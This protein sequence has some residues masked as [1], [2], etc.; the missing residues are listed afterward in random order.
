[1]ETKIDEA[2]NGNRRTYWMITFVSF[3]A[4]I[5]LLYFYPAFFWVT[6]PFLFTFFVKAIGM[7]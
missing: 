7:I 4:C 2:Q 3:V 1:M 5:A 6:L